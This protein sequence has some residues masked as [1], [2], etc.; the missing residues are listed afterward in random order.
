MGDFELMIVSRLYT[1]PRL[2][3]M[4]PLQLI[5]LAWMDFTAHSRSLDCSNFLTYVTVTAI[6][7]FSSL[8]GASM[9]PEI[10]IV[11]NICV[12]AEFF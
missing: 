6:T 8:K 7:A 3:I 4:D 2:D 10:Y 12:V 5:K 9:L 11:C 1:C